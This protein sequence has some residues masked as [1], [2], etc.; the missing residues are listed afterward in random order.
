[1]KFAIWMI[2]DKI[3]QTYNLHEKISFGYISVEVHKAVYGLKQAGKLAND[4]LQKQL[5]LNRYRPTK[6]TPGLLKHDT[7]PLA[8]TLVVNDFGVKYINIKDAKHL[9]A[10]LA[11]HY[12]MKSDWTGGRYLGIYLHWDY[13][14][15]TVT[16]TMLAYVK[17][18]LHQFQHQPSK[19]NIYSPAKY[20]PSQ[21]GAKLQLTSK[22]DRSP[23]LSPDQTTCL[24]KV[25]G[26]VLYYAQAVDGTMMNELNDLSTQTTT[27][28]QITA[29]EMEHFL[30][31]CATNP[32]AALL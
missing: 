32:D 7:R 13:K 29:A 2:P 9:E 24:Q 8:F 1:M 5:A 12:P 30:N 20:T 10:C 16:L 25:T 27:G 17:N 3:I 18:A 26:N 15:G 6:H 4:L 28:T 14:N 23:R 21:Y 22:I 11:K 19:Q 31:H